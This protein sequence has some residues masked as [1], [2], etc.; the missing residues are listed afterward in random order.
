MTLRQGKTRT[1]NRQDQFRTSCYLCLSHTIFLILISLLISLLIWLT[2]TF[3]ALGESREVPL[4]SILSFSFGLDLANI[5]IAGTGA[6]YEETGAEDKVQTS[7]EGM[8][9][10]FLSLMARVQYRHLGEVGVLG[11]P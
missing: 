11:T 10:A 9:E 1:Q 6:M 8:V 5:V 2:T 7:Q 4:I 3:S